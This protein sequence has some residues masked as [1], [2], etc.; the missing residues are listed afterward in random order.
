MQLADWVVEADCPV[1]K[2]PKCPQSHVLFVNY[3][4][5]VMLSRHQHSLT[6]LGLPL[7]RYDTI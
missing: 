4:F 5:S 7:I 1:R 3:A 6:I 2:L